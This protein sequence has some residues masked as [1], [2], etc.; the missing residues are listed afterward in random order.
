MG[1][2]K[3]ND[4]NGIVAEMLKCNCDSLNAAILDLFNDV[5]NLEKAPPDSWRQTS[6]N[7]DL[8][9]GRSSITVELPPNSDSIYFV[10]I[11]QQNAL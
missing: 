6:L 9:E 7:F 3:A 1:D 2:G 8:Q 5:L 4:R 11:V 10:Q